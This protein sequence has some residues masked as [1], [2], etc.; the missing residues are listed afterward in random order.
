MS[1]Y[2]YTW[3]L[4]ALFEGGI[5]GKAYQAELEALKIERDRLITA[6]DALDLTEHAGRQ[7]YATLLADLNNFQARL[8]HV[9]VFAQM[10]ADVDIQD[11]DAVVAL[12]KVQSLDRPY[13]LALNRFIKKLGDLNDIQW[14][15]FLTIEPMKE[16]KF[17]FNELRRDAKRLMGDG[18][19]D[20]LANL[21]ADGIHAWSSIYDTINSV[22]TIP[23]DLADGHHELSVGQAL[24]RLSADANSKNRAIIFK[25]WEETFSHYGP[26]FA[27][28]LNHL[29]G[30][31]M[32]VQKAHQYHDFLEQPLEYNRMQKATLDAMWQAV[33]EE[34]QVF[35]DYL[36]RKKSLLKLEK[37]GWQDIDAPLILGE[38]ASKEYSIDEAY[39]FVIQQ[40]GSFGPKLQ[41]FAKH[42]IESGWIEAENRPG[43]RAG[44]YCTSIKGNEESRIFMT[45][46]GSAGDASTIAHELG[47]A[48]HSSVMRDL[49]MQNQDYAMNVAETAST[50]AETIVSDANVK[51]ATTKAE[52]LT[53]L[54]NKLENATSMFM[55]IH[56]RFLFEKSFYEERQKGYVSEKRINDLMVAAQKE[57]FAGVLDEYHP[58]FWASKLHFFFDDVPFYNFP[59]T[60]GY[61]F[62]LNIYAHFLEEPE[63]F[64]EKYIALLRDT[65]SMNVEDLI[66]KH[67]NEDVTQVDFWKKGIAIAEADAKTFLE[68]TADLV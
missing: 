47:H 61:I 60:F 10:S 55:N 51:Q 26:I 2:P 57:G 68:E 17:Y 33:S 63:G 42:A 67:F 41:A 40:F 66:K 27:D 18:A 16:S 34:K 6:L 32:T 38:D 29:D 28:V 53:L 62:S 37:M 22:M 35:V 39:D 25:A 30:Y 46:T 8:N 23:V 43:K 45:F 52:R 15:D 50:L 36:N 9:A 5:T 31:E 65:G 4:D 20:L 24:N 54:A 21:N 14:D 13:Q 59:Y 19:E 3:D 11:T 49:P 44:G 56:T 48:F 1:N 12:D 64:E 7:A 58:H